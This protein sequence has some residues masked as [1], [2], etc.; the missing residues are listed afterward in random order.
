MFRPALS[1]AT[2]R[3]HVITL[4]ERRPEDMDLFF[5][6]K[7]RLHRHR[8]HLR[9]WNIP[10]IQQFRRIRTRGVMTVNANGD[11]H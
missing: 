2:E 8:S 9:F 1:F 11:G 4:S 3:D 5:A 10:H 6:L 7:V